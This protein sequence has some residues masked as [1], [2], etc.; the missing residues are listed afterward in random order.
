[1]KEVDLLETNQP[2]QEFFQDHE[3]FKYTA[4]ISYRHLEPDATIAKKVHEMIE[5]FPLPKDF[6]IDGKSPSMRVFRDREELSTRSLSDS[7]EEALRSSRFLVVI[8][9][10]RLPYSGWCNTEVE[11]FIQLRGVDHVIPVLIE[12]DPGESF[13]KVLLNY[14]VEVIREDNSKVYES[15]EILAAELRSEE[16]L[17]PDFPGFGAIEKDQ[18]QRLK[19]LTQE[20]LRLL[21]SE[22]YRIMAAILGVTYGDLFQRD[23]ARRQRKMMVLS[24]VVSFALLF[25]GLFMFNAYRKEN[26]AKRQTVQ[27]RSYFMLNKAQDLLRGG[28]RF[29]AI[30]LSNK[31][32]EDV[33]RDMEKYG[34]LRGQHLHLLNNA[35]NNVNPVFNKSV[36]TENQFSFLDFNLDGTKFYSGLKN[37]SLG[38]WDVK[39]GNLLAKAKGHSQQVKIVK[40]GSK[41]DILLSGG[42]DNL[43][44]LWDGKTLEKKASIKTPGN[45]MALSFTQEDQY[46]GAVYDTIDGV[47]YQKY[48]TKDLKPQGQPME[49]G[50]NIKRI[51]FDKEGE[52]L[53]VIYKT[54]REDQSFAKYDLTKGELEKYYPDNR[55]DNFLS[56]EDR[57]GDLA[58]MNPGLKED[59]I[60]EPYLDLYPS[61]DGSQ[62]YLRTGSYLG[63]LD[64][65]KDQFV[66]WQKEDLFTDKD[67]FKILEDPSGKYFYQADGFR[68]VKVDSATGKRIKDI[69]LGDG[70][71]LDMA[72]SEDGKVISVLKEGG[73]IFLVSQDR[74]MD[75]VPKEDKRSLDRIYLDRSGK[76][77]L[78]LSHLEQEVRIMDTSPQRNVEV[79]EGQIAGFSKNKE[80]T[81]YYSKGG[82]TIW[83]NRAKKEVRK[84]DSDL[85]PREADHL[86][87]GKGFIISGDGRYIS[88]T[89]SRVNP[90]SG[91]EEFELFILDTEKNEKVFSMP[92]PMS[93]F[94][95]EFS[96]DGKYLVLTDTINRISLLSIE[97]KK[98][99]KEISV[100]KGYISGFNLSDDNAYLS[101]NYDEGISLVYDVKTK[102]NLGSVPGTILN[103]EK[104]KDGKLE[105]VALYNNIGSK[106][107]DFK[108]SQEDVVLSPERRELGISFE[109]QN[110]Y[111]KDKDLLLTLKRLKDSQHA[112]LL[113]FKT[114][115]LIQSFDIPI[116]SYRAKGF[117]GPEG[118]TVVLD[119]FYGYTTEGEDFLSKTYDGYQRAIVYPILDYKDLLDQSKKT[120]EGVRLS[121]EDKEDLKID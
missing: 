39:T 120:V 95:F 66:Y 31:A 80:V 82:Y 43:I 58:D 83:D 30:L 24:S 25:F 51:H 61:K 92:S 3:K 17:S 55:V 36:E 65:K 67:S 96:A 118:K 77:L 23:K 115:D 26:I 44:C 48:Q 70:F 11:T 18:P 29:K 78:G 108:K 114:G 47:Y 42:F 111:N 86:Y 28:D 93:S 2:G 106:Y 59:K 8:C 32:M 35:V 98:W 40:H 62:I 112:Y 121:E 105:I 71:I 38:L 100:E 79:V 72:M 20:A 41:E 56:E 109:D 97:D 52:S 107:V 88:G 54:Y 19:G 89:A 75:F 27:D 64:I 101:V 10:K 103:L 21:K 14:Q 33:D 46:V 1:M 90:E 85:L 99:V 68:L 69:S 50:F 6:Y 7:I 12:G 116:T 9:S 49:L 84:V 76:Y 102:K 15:K 81:L 73:D 74:I 37:D 63:K 5:T 94:Y 119:S 110:F 60:S 87:D 113:D 16:V 53:F 104:N 13:P 45:V 91:L 57:Q 34:D 117:I 4:F 22:K